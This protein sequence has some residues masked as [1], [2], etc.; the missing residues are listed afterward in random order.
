MAQQVI[1]Y[2][3]VDVLRIDA[4][5]IGG[6]SE[7]LKAADYA[8]RSGIK[9]STHIHTEVHSQIAAATKNRYAGGIEYLDP[10][11]EIDLFHHLLLRPIEISD[12]KAQLSTEPGFGIEWDWKAIQRYSA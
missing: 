2:N 6:V 5:V 7:F 12:G 1:D 4:L 10:K 9:Y 3:Q 11:Y 8:D